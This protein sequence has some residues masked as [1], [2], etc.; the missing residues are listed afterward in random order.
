MTFSV[1]T[2]LL[3]NAESSLI[4][5]SNITKCACECSVALYFLLR[6]SLGG[7]GVTN[8]LSQKADVYIVSKDQIPLHR[9]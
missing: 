8:L 2:F 6:C 7:W 3:E 4:V 5:Q 9:L 1:L